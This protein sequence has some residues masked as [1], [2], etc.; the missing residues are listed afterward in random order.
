MHHQA[1]ALN[2]KSKRQAFFVLRRTNRWHI[3]G[4][5]SWALSDISLPYLKRL[6]QA[7]AIWGIVL[8]SHAI[9][10]LEDAMEQEAVI[11][12]NLG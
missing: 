1:K 11:G 6:G 2:G 8:Q 9:G 10:R 5:W 4:R 3:E 12:W 7:L